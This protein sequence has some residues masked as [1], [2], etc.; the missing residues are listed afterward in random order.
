[1]CGHS[2]FEKLVIDCV[3]PLPKSKHVHLH[4]K[5]IL[6][7][8]T[9]THYPE[10]VPL[11]TLKAQ[12]VLK[13]IVKFCTTL[14]LPRVIQTDQGSN[15][16]SNVF[17]QMLK[18]LGVLHQLSSA[19]HPESQGAIRAFSSNPEVHDQGVLGF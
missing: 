5:Y 16:T 12:I 11:R 3:E 18:E 8:C 9:D 10:A 14:G 17:G 4:V 15:F 7:M 13:E 19:Y 6:M 1:M 2:P